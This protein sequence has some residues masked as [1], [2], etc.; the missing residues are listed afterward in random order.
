MKT[1]ILI[2]LLSSLLGF[3]PLNQECAKIDIFFLIDM[4]S[5]VQGNEK[6]IG[7]AL[8][9][10]VDRFD[11]ADDGIRLSI[12]TFSYKSKL[13]LP[14]A[15]D[16]KQARIIIDDIKHYIAANNTDLY[17]GMYTVV[18]ELALKSREDVMRIIIVISDGDIDSPQSSMDIINKA[19]ELYDFNIC[20]IFINGDNG[21][22]SFM[23]EISTNGCYSESSYENLY[24][25]LK[26]LDICI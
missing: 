18:E 4:S 24:R 14:L 10:F 16:E 20:S 1:I 22:R 13:L 15:G 6:F 7:Q 9:S 26:E 11:L 8:E 19:H 17:S 21:N 12:T 3:K 23:K 5:S 25:M 2:I